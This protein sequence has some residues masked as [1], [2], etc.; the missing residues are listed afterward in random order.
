M[1]S[2][3]VGNL[4][5]FPAISE[6]QGVTLFSHPGESSIYDSPSAKGNIVAQPPLCPLNCHDNL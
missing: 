4:D 3:S 5:D 6:M 1:T 2:V